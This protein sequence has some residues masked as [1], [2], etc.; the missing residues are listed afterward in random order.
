MQKRLQ[1]G[2]EG[3]EKIK[4]HYRTELLIFCPFNALGDIYF[5]MSYLPEFQKKIGYDNAVVF[6][7]S[8]AC[9]KVVKLFKGYEVE[10]YKQ[11]ELDAIIQEVIYTGDERCFIAHQDRPYVVN[12]HKA[13]Y[14]KKIPLETIY[15]C[16]VFGLPKNTDM[17]EPDNWVE[18]PNLSDIPKGKSAIISPYAKSVPLVREK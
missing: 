17:A 12:L 11:K 6:V 2:I 4:E 16:G 5:C 14:I 7:P 13:L 18:Y 3:L 15:C 8:N 1:H 9:A 10:V